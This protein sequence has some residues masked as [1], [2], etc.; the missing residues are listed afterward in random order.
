MAGTNVSYAIAR[1]LLSPMSYGLSVQ[2]VGSGTNIIRGF[3]TP[4]YAYS[5]DMATNLAPPV[6][7]TPQITN[8]ETNINLIFTNATTLPRAFYRT[9]NVPQ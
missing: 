9:R 2:R 7:W 3:G 5:L 1:L 6:N 4:G 8:T